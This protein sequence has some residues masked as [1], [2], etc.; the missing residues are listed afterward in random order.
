MNDAATDPSQ[1]RTREDLALFLASL[2]R[3]TKDAPERWE[4]NTLG[5]FL[6]AL[7]AWTEDMDGYFTNRG[8]EVPE[9]PSWALIGQMLLAARAPGS[10]RMRP[11]TLT[12]LSCGTELRTPT[13]D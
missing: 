9:Q 12:S 13:C 2:A 1:I 6:D 4:N 8:E 10:Q 5:S 11:S 7:A 3:S